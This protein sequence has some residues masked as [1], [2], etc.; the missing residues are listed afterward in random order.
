MAAEAVRR[1]EVIA[2]PTE[3]VFGLGCDPYN[4][5]AVAE[6]L[7]LKQRPVEKGLIVIGADWQQLAPLVAPVNKQDLAQI[8][9][10]WP[11][12]ITWLLPIS[13]QTPT[14]LF[15]EHDTLAVRIPGHPLARQLCRSAGIPLVSTSANPGGL[16]PSRSAFTC[17]HYFGN[18]LGYILN[19]P[20]GGLSNP[21]QIRNLKAGKVVR[22]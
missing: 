8:Q 17:R 12:A 9:S 20:T 13:D 18:E 7:L 22:S 11:G 4:P 10:D 14:W 5:G 19:G 15:G 6:L 1:G 21:S 2:Y 16:P 3:A